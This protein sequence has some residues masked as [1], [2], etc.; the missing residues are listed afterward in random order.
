VQSV[1]LYFLMYEILYSRLWPFSCFICPNRLVWYVRWS[2]NAMPIYLSLG[3]PSS[4]GAFIWIGIFIPQGIC[5]LSWADGCLYVLLRFADLL[6]AVHTLSLE[7]MLERVRKPFA[8]PLLRHHLMHYQASLRLYLSM[9]LMLFVLVVI[10]G[11]WHWR[12]RTFR[13]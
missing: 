1:F 6:S 5:V 8:R 9:R 11:M 4:I 10:L 7:H 12:I 2:R 3:S 13:W